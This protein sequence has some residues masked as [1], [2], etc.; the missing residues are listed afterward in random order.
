MAA[1]GPYSSSLGLLIN[2]IERPR[3]RETRIPNLIYDLSRL[4]LIFATRT[5]HDGL[6]GAL[7]YAVLVLLGDGEVVADE[8]F[9]R[10]AALAGE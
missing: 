2:L 9:A 4:A 7:A 5:V 8:E 1:S 10:P 3:I 6:Y